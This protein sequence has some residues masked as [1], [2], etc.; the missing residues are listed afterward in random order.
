MQVVLQR[1]ARDEE[2]MPRLE[3]PHRLRELRCLILKTMRLVDDEILPCKLAQ[4]ILL[5][6]AHLIRRDQYIPIA[7]SARRK[8]LLDDFLPLF[9]RAVK[10]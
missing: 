1:G 4:R 6:V 3:L 9:L 5:E 7:V 2:P 8:P 10:P